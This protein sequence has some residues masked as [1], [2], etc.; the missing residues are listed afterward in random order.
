MERPAPLIKIIATFFGL[1]Y[2]PL[3]PGTAASIAGLLIF[4]LVG[5]RSAWYVL[6]TAFMLF[7]GFAVSGRAERAFDRKDSRRIVI[8]EVAGMLTALLFLPYNIRIALS[9]L[10]LFR[11]FDIAKPYPCNRL[12]H[13]SGSAGIMLD[14]IVA[15]L[16][17]NIILQAVLR[18][19]SLKVS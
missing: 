3:M 7:A 15:G 12:Q 1:G 11:I 6:I 17:A 8:D 14:D 9:G 13:L 16:Y 4:L 2:L 10:V 19:I 18:L 5:N